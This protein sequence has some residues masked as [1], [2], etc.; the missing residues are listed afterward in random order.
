MGLEA[1]AFQMLNAVIWAWVLALLALGLTLIFGYLDIVNVAHGVLYAVGAA[2]AWWMVQLTQSAWVGFLLALVVAP[3]VV[4]AIGL[5]SFQLAIRP[6]LAR[7]P[8]YTLVT[9][10]GL[11]FILQHS[12]FLVFGGEPRSVNMPIDTL[13]P[14][15]G[16]SYPLYR[17][18]MAGIAAVAIAALW[19]FLHRT[20][21]GIWIRAV[22]QNRAVATAMGIPARHVAAGVFC[23]GSALAGLAGV[24]AASVLQVRY[25]MGIDIIMDAFIVVIAAGFG[26]LPGTIVVAMIYQVIQATLVLFITPLQAK[27]LALMAVLAWVLVRRK[28]LLQRERLK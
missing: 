19:L 28:G 27:V 8:I 14:L 21:A 11:M 6:I 1:F 10:F 3:L 23:L 16:R 5:A 15:L 12:L 2:I 17:F 26:N 20:E 22:Q 25:D 7:P 18:I 24:L 13:V 4:A 9:T